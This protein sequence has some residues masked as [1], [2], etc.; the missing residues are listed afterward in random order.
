MILDASLPFRNFVVQHAVCL[1]NPIYSRKI[2]ENLK[3]HYVQL[4]GKKFGSH[5]VEKCIESCP[6]GMTYAIAEILEKNK[7][8]ELARN[9]YGNYVIQKAL[10]I[11]EVTIFPFLTVSLF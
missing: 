10:E 11:T 4:C 6:S 3:G 1:K 2:C 5:L 7:A 8:L 9:E